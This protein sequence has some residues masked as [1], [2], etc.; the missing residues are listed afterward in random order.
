MS[1]FILVVLAFAAFAAFEADALTDEARQ[2]LSNELREFLNEQ[3][4]RQA[5]QSNLATF[6]QRR[7]VRY[8]QNYIMDQFLRIQRSNF[9]H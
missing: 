7:L 2:F 8:S 5:D 1:K 4:M 3:E 6:L 9:I